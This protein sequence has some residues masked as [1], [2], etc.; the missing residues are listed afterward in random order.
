MS[1]EPPPASLEPK[2][3]RS[4]RTRQRLLDAAEA[5]ILE[6]GISDVSVTDIVQAA[7]SSVGGFYRRFRDKDG[8]LMALY[9]RTYTD[10]E[11]RL[12]QIEALAEDASIDLPTLVRL[13]L[14]QLG[15]IFGK[16]R[17]L[18]AAY[19]A[20]AVRDPE[21]WAITRTRRADV[22]ARLARVIARRGEV[23]AHPDPERAGAIAVHMALAFSDEQALA[24][25]LP[26]EGSPLSDLEMVLEL[27][28][29]ILRYL[30]GGDPVRQAHPRRLSSR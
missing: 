21:R 8:L 25:G 13:S 6:R 29:A 10:V 28:R 12:T 16:R 22:V 15:E 9:D 2:Q 17:A 26:V 23:I 1:T 18:A 20:S 7:R 11:A 19:L 5:L 30:M 3:A 14:A 24:G 27:E 4:E